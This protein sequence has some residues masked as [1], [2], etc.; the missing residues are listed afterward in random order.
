MTGLRNI[1]TNVVLRCLSLYIVR[2]F[3]SLLFTSIKMYIIRIAFHGK[4]FYSCFSMISL[5][6]IIDK[7]KV[8]RRENKGDVQFKFESFVDISPVQNNIKTVYHC[9]YSPHLLFVFVF[10]FLRSSNILTIITK[11]LE[12]N[13]KIIQCSCFVTS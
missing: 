9:R 3:V 8:T 5:L 10:F 11:C 13:L 6:R 12:H 2:P 1:W 7:P 4:S